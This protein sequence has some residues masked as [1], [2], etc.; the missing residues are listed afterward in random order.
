MSDDYWSTPDAA[1]NM[2][3]FGKQAGLREGYQQ[4]FQEGRHQGFQEGAA[5]MLER[6]EATIAQLREEIN[7]LREFSN[8]A[9]ITLDAAAEVLAATGN[10]KQMGDFIS[11]YA[12]GVELSVRQRHFSLA[13]HADKRFAA[14]MPRIAQIINETL[15]KYLHR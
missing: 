2:G 10:Q 7:N 8:G 3:L 14:R 5:A 15:S 11:S 1:Y 13:P 9:V 6:M 12:Q 4:G